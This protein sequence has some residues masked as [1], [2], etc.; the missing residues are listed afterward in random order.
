LGASQRPTIT[1]SEKLAEKKKKNLDGKKRQNVLYRKE[2]RTCSSRVGEKHQPHRR[3][4]KGGGV[5]GGA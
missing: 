1:H 3:A 4:I 5:L 2:K